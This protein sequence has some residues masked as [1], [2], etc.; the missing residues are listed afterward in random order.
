MIWQKHILAKLVLLLCD[1]NKLIHVQPHLLIPTHTPV[2]FALSKM[3]KWKFGAHTH[4]IL[5][6]NTLL[7]KHIQWMSAFL[8]CSMP[9]ISTLLKKMKECRVDSIFSSKTEGVGST[10]SWIYCTRYVWCIFWRSSGSE[11]GI[12]SLKRAVLVRNSRCRRGCGSAGSNS[13]QPITSIMHSSENITSNSAVRLSRKMPL[14]ISYRWCSPSVLSKSSHI[15]NS[16]RSLRIYPSFSTA[17]ASFSRR[18]GDGS[19]EATSSARSSKRFSSHGGNSRPGDDISSKR[20]SS[21]SST[22]SWVISTDGSFPWTLT[23]R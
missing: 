22:T 10:M 1:I 20:S 4:L 14:I 23:K 19:E 17:S 7:W 2:D 16:S 13:R 6:R 15:R 3:L 21:D 11:M 18:S 12:T 9:T 8:T 5:K